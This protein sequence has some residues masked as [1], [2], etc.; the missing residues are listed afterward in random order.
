MLC[1]CALHFGDSVNVQNNIVANT[2]SLYQLRHDLNSSRRK[3]DEEMW[4]NL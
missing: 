1:K 4:K 3:Y 2:R